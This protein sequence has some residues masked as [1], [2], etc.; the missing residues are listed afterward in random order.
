MNVVPIFICLLNCLGDC[1]NDIT[2]QFST[3]EE[4]TTFGPKNVNWTHP[5]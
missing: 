3:F 5:D 4:L 2:L 1:I